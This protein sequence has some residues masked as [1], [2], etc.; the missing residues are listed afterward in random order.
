LG[1]FAAMTKVEGSGGNVGKMH[2]VNIG[3]KLLPI[4]G[5]A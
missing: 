3:E 5:R 4:A 1:I 2:C